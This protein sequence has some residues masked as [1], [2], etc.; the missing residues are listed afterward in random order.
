MNVREGCRIITV[1]E[2]RRAMTDG[3]C[4]V[5]T[6]RKKSRVI[7]NREGC[8]I[9]VLTEGCRIMTDSDGCRIVT[10]GEGWRIMTLRDGSR[11]VIYKLLS[12][13]LCIRRVD[14]YC[15]R[16]IS[17]RN[18]QD[19]KFIHVQFRPLGIKYLN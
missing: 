8:P 13:Y 10:V 2:E 17:F 18:W 11:I 7:T 12:D 15:Q 3:V 19:S 5:T 9:E 6:V 16:R 1:R 4:R 14:R